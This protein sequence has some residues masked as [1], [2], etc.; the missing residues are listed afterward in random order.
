MPTRLQAYREHAKEAAQTHLHENTRVLMTEVAQRRDLSGI[1][2]GHYSR[3]TTAQGKVLLIKSFTSEIEDNDV[4]QHPEVFEKIASIAL[5]QEFDLRASTL[6]LK[7]ADGREPSDS[8]I[9]GFTQET[10]IGL[11]QD[12]QFIPL[13]PGNYKLGVVDNIVKLVPFSQIE[14]YDDLR[15]S[16]TNKANAAAS[17]KDVQA[18]YLM[19]IQESPG[20]HV[21]CVLQQIVYTSKME[22]DL[23]VLSDNEAH[24][25][26]QVADRATDIKV[27]AVENSNVIKMSEQEGA[28]LVEA[29]KRVASLLEFRQRSETRSVEK[30]KNQETLTETLDNALGEGTDAEVVLLQNE[31]EMTGFE[32]KSVTKTELTKLVGLKRSMSDGYKRDRSGLRFGGIANG[33]E[34][35]SS[36]MEFDVR[37]S[38]SDP[39]VPDTL[40]YESE[41]AS[42]GQINITWK[43]V[44]EGTARSRRFALTVEADTIKDDRYSLRFEYVPQEGDSEDEF[45]LSDSVRS[46]ISSV[47][48]SLNSANVRR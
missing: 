37:Y 12:K 29:Q 8:P 1:V 3:E 42:R 6:T 25:L 41:P 17:E 33:G 19:S 21:K 26:R 15:I 35:V 32:I 9:I 38:S 40:K 24:T 20:N 46:V 14:T 10:G 28:E 43:D 27:I 36:D 18:S 23:Q 2:T 5:P 4:K 7:F 48:K 45:P 44:E 22:M 34:I 11:V 31:G 30:K 39:Y 47:A 13:K 16:A